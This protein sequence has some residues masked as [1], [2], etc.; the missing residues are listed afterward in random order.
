MLKSPKRGLGLAA[1]MFTTVD[2]W[3]QP[4]KRNRSMF[5][6]RRFQD[7]ELGADRM[8]E[9]KK[10]ETQMLIDRILGKGLSIEGIAATCGVNVQTVYRWKL[11]KNRPHKTFRKRLGS[12]V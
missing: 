3:R 4:A 10:N 6:E 9:P 11:G 8:N 1:R 2:L 12:L 7:R 5:G